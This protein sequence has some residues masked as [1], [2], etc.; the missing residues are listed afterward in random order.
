MKN[1]L[2]KAGGAPLIWD[3]DL[4][5]EGLA[6]QF[7]SGNFFGTIGGFSA[8]ERSSS[9]D[10]LLYAVQAGVRFPLG[11]A[12]SLI[13]GVGYFAYTDTIGNE[14]F[15]DGSANGNSIDL[16]GDYVY[17]YRNTEFFAELNTSVGDWPFKVYA[18]AKQ[19]N[20]APTEDT[21]LA[22]GAKLGSA[23]KDGEME[24]SWTCQDIQAEAF[25]YPE[26]FF[27]P[28]VWRV[29]RPRPDVE[30]LVAAAELLRKADKPLIG[31]AEFAAMKD[32]VVIVN[33]A[34]GGIV[35]ERALAAA[36]E[37]GTI[38]AAAIDVFEVEPIRA[39]NPL[40][41]LDNCMLTSHVAGIASD[42]TA[43]IWSWAHENVRRVVQRGDQAIPPVAQALVIQF[44]RIQF[45]ELFDELVDGPRPDVQRRQRIEM[46]ADREQDI[47]RGGHFAQGLALD[48]EKV[49][50]ET[51]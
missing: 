47:L 36:L 35:D 4:N 6:L 16:D 28:K 1:P 24:F 45:A 2:F 48:A 3:G 41:G 10:S 15:Y 20:D 5:P 22:V 9:D 38:A 27:E 23:K 30:Q 32:G 13:A 11:N 18:H 19:N 39:D 14:P 7:A 50:G 8:E 40:I 29:P 49:A 25:D 51:V 33:T 42:T 21:V 37:N 26:A 12:V 46:D 44:R 31:P 34:R 17:D 43:R